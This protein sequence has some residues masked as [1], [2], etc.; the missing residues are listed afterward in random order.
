MEWQTITHL[1]GV[2]RL[3]VNYFQPSFKLIEKTRNGSA[4]IKRYSSPATPC[5]RVISHEAVSA[6]AKAALAERRATLD[7]VALLQPSGKRNRPWRPS[8]PRS[9]GQILVSKAWSAFWPDYPT[10]GWR[11]KSM[12]VGNPE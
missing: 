1:H 7:P 3:Y 10:G 11:N 8:Y 4:V 6:C 5:D 12:P 9:S 2:L